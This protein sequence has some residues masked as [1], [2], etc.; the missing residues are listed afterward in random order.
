VLC[1]MRCEREWVIENVN[2]CVCL[3]P[4][5]STKMQISIVVYIWSTVSAKY[6]L[7]LY[8]YVYIWATV[9]MVYMV[10]IWYPIIYG[11]YG[12]YGRI[13]YING[14]YGIYGQLCC[15]SNQTNDLARIQYPHKFS[16]NRE[17]WFA[18]LKKNLIC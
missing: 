12:I 5:A 13:I 18:H 7:L 3:V 8:I 11:I 9:Y 17:V 16:L 1:Q 2:V 10:Y 4:N 14:I 6:S 15:S